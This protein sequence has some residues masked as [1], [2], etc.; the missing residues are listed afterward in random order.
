MFLEHTWNLS[1]LETNSGP[2]RDLE[3]GTRARVLSGPH[4][5]DVVQVREAESP[6]VVRVSTDRRDR[7][8]DAMP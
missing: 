6:D 8:R 4:A 5:H 7:T 1:S 2:G 3:P